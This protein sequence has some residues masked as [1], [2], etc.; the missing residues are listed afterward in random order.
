M[1]GER[2][3]KKLTE[4]ENLREEYDDFEGKD[5]FLK[6]KS[7]KFYTLKDVSILTNG[8]KGLDKYN[9]LTIVAF[10]EIAEIKIISGLSWNDGRN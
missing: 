10:S 1:K 5:I 2:K 6:T 9:D 3:W 4:E 7:K 8:I